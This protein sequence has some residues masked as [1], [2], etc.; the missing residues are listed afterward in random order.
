MK[1]LND[2]DLDGSNLQ[3][4]QMKRARVC[5]SEVNG[6]V[7][8]QQTAALRFEGSGYI[9]QSPPGARNHPPTQQA[10]PIYS[11]IVHSQPPPM[12]LHVNQGNIS[13][14]GV[15]CRRCLARSF[16][17]QVGMND[18]PDLDR[19]HPPPLQAAQNIPKYN[20][21]YRQNSNAFAENNAVV[22]D[23]Y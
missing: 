4:E 2:T 10:N 7:N 14:S 1:S 3:P 17:N 13:N 11:N 9:V 20:A 18:D 5:Q 16:G 19:I 21:D 12:Q 23:D 6:G 15:P 8:Q 22:G